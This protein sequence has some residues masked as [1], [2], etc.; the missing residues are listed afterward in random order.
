M[1]MDPYLNSENQIPRIKKDIFSG[2]HS[3]MT[4]NILNH[5]KR[6]S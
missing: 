4:Q 5:R 2:V 1:T 3:K 6:N